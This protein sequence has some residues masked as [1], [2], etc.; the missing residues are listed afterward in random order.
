M[1]YELMLVIQGQIP[2]ELS[3]EVV[4]KVKNTITE[5]GGERINEDFW[6]RRKLAYKIENQE[7]GY[8]DVLNFSIEAE[9]IKKLE[10]EIK[11]INEIIRYLII[12]KIERVAEKPKARKEIKE[13]AVIARVTEKEKEEIKEK[14]VL[15]KKEGLQIPEEKKREEP[16]IEKDKAEKKVEEIKEVKPE[17]KEPKEEKVEVKTTEKERLK[18]LD[19]KIDEL[20][21][22]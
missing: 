18:E 19:K 15:E 4:N 1:S 14:L 8:Y 17:E 13:K 6:G 21:K 11:L 16:K 12:K 2:E 22:E 9:N 20:L 3:K 5:L 10:N 7:H